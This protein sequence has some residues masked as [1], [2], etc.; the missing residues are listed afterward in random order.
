[1]GGSYTKEK[2]S[3]LSFSLI[4]I[5]EKLNTYLDNFENV[6]LNFDSISLNYYVNKFLEVNYKH[7]FV[8]ITFEGNNYYIDFQGDDIFNSEVII[9]NALKK[10]SN[11]IDLT[12]INDINR[13]EYLVRII[14]CLSI[15]NYSLIFRNCEHVSNYIY[16]N[17]WASFQT[18]NK[19][20]VLFNQYKNYLIGDLLIKINVKPM[21]IDLDILYV[22]NIKFKN[23]YSDYLIKLQTKRILDE[24]HFRSV[25]ELIS[26]NYNITYERK[27]DSG[28]FISDDTHVILIIGPTGAGKSRLINLIFNTVVA[29]SELSSNSCTKEIIF[30][31]GKINGPEVSDKKLCVIDTVGLCDSMLSQTEVLLLLKD[32]INIISH[33]NKIF[34]VVNHKHEK[35]H[36]E[37]IMNIF[38]WLSVIQLPSLVHFIITK[39]EGIKIDITKKLIEEYKSKYSQYSDDLIITIKITKEKAT[40]PKIICVGFPD[41]SIYKE[42]Y[43][44]MMQEDINVDYKK[45]ILST[46]IFGTTLEIEKTKIFKF[47]NLF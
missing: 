15:S 37:G 26:R 27:D 3:W 10:E 4:R 11:V 43:L 14:N 41:S 36:Y 47:C 22:K 30:Y 31:Y 33:I 21:G 9:H 38:D 44:K 19:K 35:G 5:Y 24:Q 20:G 7:F 6:L 45:F 12:K 16:R 42:N 25:S 2:E 34:V 8:V 40:I 17:C 18:S 23:I 39:C 13:T 32:R 29:F 46:M 1:M 28:L